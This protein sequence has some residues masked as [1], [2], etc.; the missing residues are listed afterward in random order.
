MRKYWLAPGVTDTGRLNAP[1]VP[2]TLGPDGFQV[3]S[4]KSFLKTT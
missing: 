2:G 1:P 4:L 3:G